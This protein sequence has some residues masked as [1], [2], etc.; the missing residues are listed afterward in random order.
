MEI[1]LIPLSDFITKINSDFPSSFDRLE[2][3]ALVI[4]K[5]KQICDYN[6]F[7]NRKLTYDMFEGDSKIFD[8]GAYV[9]MQPSTQWNYYQIEGKKIFQD[10]N[11]GSNCSLGLKIGDLVG[12]GLTVDFK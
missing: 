10:S 5:Y 9:D 4:D 8:S 6:K 12:L 3:Q 1:S 2:M 7:L 11:Y